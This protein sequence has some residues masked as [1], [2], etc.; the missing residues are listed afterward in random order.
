MKFYLRPAKHILQLNLAAAPSLFRNWSQILFLRPI[1]FMTELVCSRFNIRYEV[2]CCV[3]QEGCCWLQKPGS[4]LAIAD[5]SSVW[6]CVRIHPVHWRRLF[7]FWDN[8]HV[9]NMVQSEESASP[10]KRSISH[11]PMNRI[12][13]L[14]C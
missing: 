7:T 2:C 8:T 3:L 12:K 6:L 13:C 9:F 4:A 10:F 11:Q 1:V 5:L 14:I